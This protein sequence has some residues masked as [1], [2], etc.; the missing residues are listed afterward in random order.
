MNRFTDFDS[1]NGDAPI[2][3]SMS[4]SQREFL[5]KWESLMA[6]E[7]NEVR[8]GRQELFG[9]TS[10]DREELGRCALGDRRKR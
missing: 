4:P 6:L 3:T 8:K 2:F 7:E 10:Q 5:S 9:M 1:E